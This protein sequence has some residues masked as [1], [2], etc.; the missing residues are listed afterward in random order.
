MVLEILTFVETIVA[1]RVTGFY[2][3]CLW[4]LEGKLEPP[5]RTHLPSP[6]QSLRGLKINSSLQ[7]IFTT[8]SWYESPSSAEHGDI[9]NRLILINYR[10]G[11][12][13]SFGAVRCCVDD[14]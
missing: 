14:P 12:I 8:T 11:P 3:A 5:Q 13:G 2:K 10:G 9:G 4:E 7:K 6:K 1:S